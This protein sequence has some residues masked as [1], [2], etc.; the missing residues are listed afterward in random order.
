MNAARSRTIRIHARPGAPAIAVHDARVVATGHSGRFGR[1]VTLRDAYGNRF[2]YGHL[3]GVARGVR[4]GMRI[5]GGGVVGRVGRSHLSFR[6]RPAGRGAPWIDPTPL[7][8]GWKLLDSTALHR[9]TEASSPGQVLLL[10]KG[11]LARRVLAD[12]RLDVYACGRRDIAAGVIDR[13][14]LA[15]LA[16]LSASGLEPTVTSLRCGHGRLTSSGNVSEHASGSAVDIAAVNGI[17]IGGH[18]GAGSIT[19]LTVRRL[20]TLQGAV[21]PHQIISLMTFPGADNAFAMSD[22]ADHIHVG[23]RPGY[24]AVGRIDASLRPGQWTRLIGRLSRIENP[25]KPPSGSPRGSRVAAGCRWFP[26]PLHRCRSSPQRTR[27][28]CQAARA[29]PDPARG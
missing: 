3:A 4:S 27:P 25:L 13:R 19:E 7:L 17:P 5:A 22:H 21:R 10:G 28:S 2:T 6:V 24:G 23:W 18:Q 20:L 12:P 8:D 11:A 16:F 15:T 29:R 26:S 9:T 1:F 14:V